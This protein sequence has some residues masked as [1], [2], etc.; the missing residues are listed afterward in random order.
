MGVMAYVLAALGGYLLGAIPFG[1]LLTRWAGLGDIRAIGSHSIGATNVLRTGR[2]DIAL[3]TLVLDALK[4]G[5]ALVVAR[6]LAPDG[7]SPYIL[8][9]IAGGAAFVG[10][11]YPVWLGFK[12]GKGVATFFGLLFAGMWPIGFVAGVTWLAIAAIF[13]FSS[14]ASL[15]AAAAAPIFALAGGSPDSEG[16][17]FCTFLAVLIFWRHRANIQR[18]LNGT[19]SKI[20]Q[21][22]ELPPAPPP[23]APNPPPAE[24]GS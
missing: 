6:M 7:V 12:G 15:C 23:A 10:H 18:L 16:V 5:I 24:A 22:A 3:A 8:G 19:E 20:G 17:I 4:A 13:R 21:K 2:K 1:L 14:L 9:Y 11:C